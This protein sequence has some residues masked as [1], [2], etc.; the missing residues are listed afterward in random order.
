MNGPVLEILIPMVY[1]QEDFDQRL[2]SEL[3]DQFARNNLNFG[4]DVLITV[5]PDNGRLT[6]GEKRNKLLEQ[7]QA[8]YIAFFDVDDLPGE[9]YIKTLLDGIKKDVDVVSLRGIYT[10]D[11][12]SPE[13][14]EHSLK[15]CEYKTIDKATTNEVKHERFPNHLNCMK[16]LIAQQ[17]KFPEKN[18]GEDTAWATKINEAGALKTE[19]YSDEIIYY[20]IYRTHK[21]EM[22][23]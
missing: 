20:Y 19:H 16:R 15:Y 14:F 2:T 8:K 17:F 10:V 22:K 1:G 7:S 18:H 11:G 13:I 5:F 21:P 3:M 12:R 9:H 4:E 23:S 6:I